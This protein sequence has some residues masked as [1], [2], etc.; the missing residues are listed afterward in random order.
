MPHSKAAFACTLVLALIGGCARRERSEDALARSQETFLRGQIAG[1]EKMIGQVERGELTTTDQVAIGLSEDLAKRLLNASLPLETIVAKRL[2]LRVDSAEPFFRGTKA[3]LLFKATVS[4]VDVSGASASLDIG[5]A[6]DHFELK[7]GRLRARAQLGHFAVRESGLGELAA[8]AI[9]ALVRA[10]A[11]AIQSAIPGLEVPVEIDESV[12]IGGFAEGPV[13][14]RPGAL[15]LDIAVSQVI[16]GNRR[17]W[18]LLKAEAGRWQPAAEPAA[19]S[20]EA[21]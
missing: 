9:D 6:L 16:V 3:A 19:K 8:D 20:Q 21:P 10:N 2:R 18:V 7:D 1:L 15:P 4:S 12:A 14:A 17:L 13:L 5:G 11:A